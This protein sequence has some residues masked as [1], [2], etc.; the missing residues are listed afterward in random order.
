MTSLPPTPWSPTGSHPKTASAL[1]G[2]LT[3]PQHLPHDR[4][5]DQLLPATQQRH[6]DQF[7][8][9]HP[10]GLHCVPGQHD[11]RA[12]RHGRQN[13]THRYANTLTNSTG[14]KTFFLGETLLLEE[15]DWKCMINNWIIQLKLDQKNIINRSQ[16]KKISISVISFQDVQGYLEWGTDN[17][18]PHLLSPSYF[19]QPAGL[20]LPKDNVSPRHT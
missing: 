2:Q 17:D 8:D 9:Q 6:P 14:K 11:G 10:P 5:R 16:G 18:V 15:N 7:Q 4:G 13:A 19:W 12:S 20:G 1:R 3:D